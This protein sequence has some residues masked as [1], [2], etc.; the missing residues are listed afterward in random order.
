MIPRPDC[1][2]AVFSLS[3]LLAL[4]QRFYFS[5]RLKIMKQLTMMYLKFFNH[6]TLTKRIKKYL[7]YEILL[8]EIRVGNLKGTG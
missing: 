6:I 4:R 1:R 8:L 5:L 7:E 3:I 2:F